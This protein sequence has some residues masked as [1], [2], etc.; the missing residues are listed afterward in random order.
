M[1]V[2]TISREL[3]SE[4]DKIADLLCES[5]GYCRVDKDM[6]TQIAQD[7]G[8]DVKAV[9]AKERAST[10]RARLISADMTSLHRKQPSAFERKGAMDDQTYARILRE[11]ME[12]FAQEGEAVIVGR[13]GQMVLRDW[14]EALHVHLYAPS[15]VRVRRLVERLGISKREAEQR[16]TQ[17][18]EQK[19][20]T[21]RHMHKNANWKNLRYYDLAINT[22]AICP[23]VAARI[24]IEATKQKAHA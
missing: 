13:G 1:T 16:I 14:P 21:I 11:T 9:L 12:R 2:L 23:E 24:I 8:V 15:E 22:G 20:Q 6:L 5:L 10:R 7:A 17:S 3:G 19:R 18:D 4:G